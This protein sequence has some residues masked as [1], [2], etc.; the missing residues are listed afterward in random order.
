[1]LLARDSAI[2]RLIAVV[3]CQRS[4]TTLTGQIIGAHPNAILVDETDGLYPWFHAEADERHDAEAL[5]QAMLASAAA[6]Y[7][8]PGARF[9]NAAGRVTVA[10]GVTNLILKV[11]NLTYDYEKLSRIPIPVMVVY[12]VRD[13]RGVVASMT[14]LSQIDFIGNQL[15]L[16]AERPGTAALFEAELRTLANAAA[17]LW[18]RH[19]AIWKVKS[20]LMPEFQRCGLA[21]H[22]FRYEDLVREP[23]ATCRHLLS[24]CDLRV[25]GELARPEVVYRGFGPG[26]TDRMR[27]IDQAALL[28]WERDLDTSREADILHIAGQLA[29]NFGYG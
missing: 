4:G 18:V 11:P 17:P 1:L 10:D 8:N 5:G 21:V 14:R 26:G 9:R 7:R 27:P 24:A 28:N 29:K 13:P 16:L 15:C 6:K 12:P 3:G 23:Q 22:Q 25:V 20:G 19:A 2:A